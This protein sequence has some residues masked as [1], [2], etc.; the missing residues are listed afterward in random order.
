[1]LL[2]LAGLAAPQ[3]AAAQWQPID[4]G[5]PNIPQRTPVWC[6]AAVTE[7]V[8]RWRNGGA[9][10]SQAELVA[11]ANGFSPQACLQLPNQMVYQACMR[12]G[13][14]GEIQQLLAHFGGGA[15]FAAPPAHPV[16]LYNMLA[17]QRPVILAVQTTPFSGH[18][19][20]LRGM[21]PAPDPLLLIND[22]MRWSAFGQPLPF[23]ALMGFW[24][25]AIV[26]V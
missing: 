16:H 14:L 11:L 25:A 20:V 22:P 26:V 1:M 23:S 15:S 3:G 12:T 6:W 7:Q 5:I 2:T 19:V 24:S 4:L 13:G 8:I 18:V 21:L 17:Q 9:G 10:P